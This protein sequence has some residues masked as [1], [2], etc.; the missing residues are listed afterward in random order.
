MKEMK[1]I[2]WLEGPE[3]MPFPGESR[4]TKK[5]YAVTERGCEALGLEW[6]KARLPGK[7][8]LKS[9]L[10]ERMIGE[11]LERQGKAVRYEYSLRSDEVTK[12]ADVAVLETDGS[13]VAYEYKE[14]IEH[15]VENI[16]RNRAAGFVKTVVVFR[17]DTVRK[18]VIKRRRRR[19]VPCSLE[20]LPDA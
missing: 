3:S 19:V 18:K 13:V 6:K 5:C 20:K 17:N 10:A 1:E 4:R 2:G 11:Q 14:G 9:R 7:G 8:S 16:E 12:A 15:V